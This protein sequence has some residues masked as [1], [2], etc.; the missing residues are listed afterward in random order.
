MLIL[1]LFIYNRFVSLAVLEKLWISSVLILL[2]PYSMFKMCCSLLYTGQWSVRCSI[3]HID[4]R[5]AV[6]FGWKHENGLDVYDQFQ[7]WL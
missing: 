4:G 1:K 2:D 5:L 7:L 6:L 3:D